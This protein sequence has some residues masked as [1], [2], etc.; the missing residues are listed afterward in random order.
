MQYRVP[1]VLAKIL[2]ASRTG[3]DPTQHLT[4]PLVLE[5][6]RTPQIL[7]H[8]LYAIS[9]FILAIVLWATLCDVREVTFAPG[10]I[11]PSGQVQIVNHLEGGIVAELFVR[12]GDPVVEGQPLM[13]LEPVAAG[14]DL[15][16]LQVHRSGLLLQIIRL[17]AATR[18]TTPDF[19][20]TGAA[21][22]ELA[23]G[24]AKLY[25][26]T[27]EQLRQ[28]RAVLAARLAQRR[29][30]VAT[31]SAALETAKAQVPVARDLFDIQ[32]K[33]IHMGYTPTKL[34]LEAKSA[35]LRA[36]GDTLVAEAKVRT[37]LEAQT[38]AESALAAATTTALQKFAE[39]RAKASNDVAETEWQ[40]AKFT[41]RFERVVVRAPSAGLVQEMV[42]KAPGEVV[43]PGEM[44]ARIVPSG[45]DLVAEVRIDT[46]DSGFVHIGTPADVKFAT[47]D[48]ALFGTLTGTVDHI[49]ATTFPPQPGQPPLSGQSA[50]EP[51]Y[52]AI[53]H[54]ST[55]HVGTGTMSRPI[56]AGMVVQASI[57]TGSKSI[58]RYLLK[59]VANSLDVAFTER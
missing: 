46:K 17:D 37:A 6:G 30:D 50:L 23:A 33:L 41:D 56:S 40:V 38:E 8:T 16:Q 25:A 39:E 31:N 43:K 27:M 57:V 4:Q 10:Q 45:Y 22:P 9:A 51:Y 26:S 35:L 20:A 32:S 28:D 47:Y 21:Y 48:T 52:K 15:E 49:S 11:I 14:S 5:D 36:E 55:N 7:S 42:P 1:A 3:S 19:G 12:E 44:V 18:G 13:R 24:Q 34:Y 59:P 53:I 58:M 2:S 29:D 54:L